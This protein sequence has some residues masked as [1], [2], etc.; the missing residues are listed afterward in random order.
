MPCHPGSVPSLNSQCS[1]QSLLAPKVGELFALP[2][3][4]TMAGPTKSGHQVQGLGKPPWWPK[5]QSHRGVGDRYTVWC[6]CP[7]PV[8]LCLHR[9]G[10]DGAGTRGLAYRDRSKRSSQETTALGDG[11]V[12][13]PLSEGLCL[14]QCQLLSLIPVQPKATTP[15][16]TR[17]MA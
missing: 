9:G 17:L 7:R 13:P 12:S 6:W 4:P 2:G 15:T 10:G 3:C 11:A 16:A 1:S 14:P 8:P 5:W